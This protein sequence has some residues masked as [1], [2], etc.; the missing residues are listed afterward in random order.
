MGV[1]VN[2][3]GSRI[4]QL[5]SQPEQP[6]ESAQ[7]PEPVQEEVLQ[8]EP[9]SQAEYEGD[10]GE[11]SDDDYEPQGPEVEGDDT[12]PEEPKYKVKVNGEEKEVGL[13]DLRKGYMMESDYRRKTSEVARMRDEIE[14]Q[15]QQ[16]SEKLSEAEEMLKLEMADLNEEEKEYDPASYYEKKERL[17]SKRNRLKELKA[18]ASK[19]DQQKQ[20]ALIEKEQQRLM[21]SLPEWLDQDVL[22]KEVGLIQNLWDSYGFT[23]DEK[24]RFTDH[25]LALI[26]RKAALYDQLMKNKPVNKKVTPKPKT[27]SPGVPKT[28]EQKAKEKSLRARSTV[29]KTGRMHDAA[30]AI[31]ELMR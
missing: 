21:E 23:E 19:A 14:Q 1:D 5:F 12:E 26:S 6:S 28:A 8:E 13:E 31:K 16:F 30:K 24:S 20:Q 27:A 25:R 7:K 15:R 9:E 10:D 2:Q 18:E 17:E 29:K 3:A 22:T 4:A 11:T